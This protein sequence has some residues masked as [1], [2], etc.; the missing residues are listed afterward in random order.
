MNR[1]WP[2]TL[3]RELFEILINAFGPMDDKYGYHQWEDVFNSLGI[4]LEDQLYEDIG[5]GYDR[6]L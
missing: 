3:E 6:R 5:D 2:I 4:D 1:F